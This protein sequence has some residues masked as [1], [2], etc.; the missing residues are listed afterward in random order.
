MASMTENDSFFFLSWHTSREL[1]AASTASTLAAYLQLDV[2]AFLR[3]PAVDR[4]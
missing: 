2:D 4:R 3:E 1:Q